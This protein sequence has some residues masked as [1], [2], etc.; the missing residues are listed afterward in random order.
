MSAE[1]DLTEDRLLDG[2]VILHQPRRGYR[3]AIDPVLLAAAVP[4]VPGQKILDVGCGT[5]A[6]FLCVAARVPDV[7]VTSIERNP[8]LLALA[9]RNAAAN[10]VDA[11]LIEGD[12]LNPPDCLS[13]VVFDHVVSNP[14]FWADHATRRRSAPTAAGAHQMPQEALAAWL[15]FCV[16]RL[17]PNGVFS[18]IMPPTRL[19]ETYQVLE[20][21][22]LF[23]SVF[24]LFSKLGGAVKRLILQA[25]ADNVGGGEK[26][27][28]LVLHDDN[29]AYTQAAQ[30]L[31]RQGRAL[32]I[33]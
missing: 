32:K 26:P 4:A 8:L 20:A 18:L 29:G 13:G 24:P 3:V 6:I 1:D 12:V 5:G 30:R 11:T 14:P 16:D 33:V 17:A 10:G 27:T 31:L 7:H 21:K 25:S 19:D 9:R 2:R 23:Y 28:G 22:G 15:E